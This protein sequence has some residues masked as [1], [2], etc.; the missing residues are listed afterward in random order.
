MNQ[1]KSGDQKWKNYVKFKRKKLVGTL[2]HSRK[3]ALRS[4]GN[5]WVHNHYLIFSHKTHLLEQ[6]VRAAVMSPIVVLAL[7]TPERITQSE[8]NSL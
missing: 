7:H 6:A 2:K 1:R 8:L 5:Y 3:S 4:I